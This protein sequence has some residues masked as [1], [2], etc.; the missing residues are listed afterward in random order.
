MTFIFFPR[1]IK[2]HG[3]LLVFKSKNY[4]TYV[5]I[6][7]SNDVFFFLACPAKCEE[8]LTGDGVCE[9]AC[10][11]E[12][13]DFVDIDCNVLIKRNNLFVFVEWIVMAMCKCLKKKKSFKIFGGIIG[14]IQD[15]GKRWFFVNFWNGNDQKKTT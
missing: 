11:I 9:K 10:D 6:I 14:S 12:E 1:G 4:L 13:C 3:Y 5:G 15:F 7:F 8:D 2:T